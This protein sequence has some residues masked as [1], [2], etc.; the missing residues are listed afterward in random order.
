[1]NTRKRI[2]TQSCNCNGLIFSWADCLFKVFI[3]AFNSF[4]HVYRSHIHLHLGDCPQRVVKC[5][6]KGCHNFYALEEEAE[7]D[8]QYQESHQVLL[9]QEV[10]RLRGIIFDQVGDVRLSLPWYSV[11][12]IVS[13]YS[14]VSWLPLFSFPQWSTWQNSKFLRRSCCFCCCSKRRVLRFTWCDKRCQWLRFR[15]LSIVKLA[16]AVLSVQLSISMLNCSGLRAIVYRGG[17]LHILIHSRE[18]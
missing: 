2:T 5:T 3:D 14:S 13:V 16:K 9:K 12:V 6:V 8:K 18:F 11:T 4:V 10:E 1:M 7:H 15:I 17:V